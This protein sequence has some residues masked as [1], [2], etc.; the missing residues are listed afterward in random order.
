[1]LSYLCVFS[2]CHTY[3]WPL[4]IEWSV[5][6][7]SHLHLLTRSLHWVHEKFRVEVKI[8]LLTYKTHCE[9]HP[10]FYRATEPGFAGDIGAIEVWL[11]DR[12]SID[13]SSLHTGH[14]SLKSNKGITLPVP[15]VKT[16][17]GT[18][19]FHS[20]A[21]FLWNNLLLSVHLA[22]SIATFRK[23]LKPH[24]FDLTCKFPRKTLPCPM[25]CWCY[26]AALS[27][28]LLNTDSAVAPLSLPT[29]GI[30]GL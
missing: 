2:I 23:H 7:Q 1:M 9:N 24:L 13:W 19:A 14:I 15:R 18:W 3:D 20:C 16:N 29:L 17:T 25:A 21:P 27:I 10:V 12:S 8:Y 5:L 22:T 30:L 26:R 11:I 28:L 4:N 6:G